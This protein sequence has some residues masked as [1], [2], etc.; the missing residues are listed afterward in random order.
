MVRAACHLTRA[1]PG[2][3]VMSDENDVKPDESDEPAERAIDGDPESFDR[4]KMRY[5]QLCEEGRPGC[6][7]LRGA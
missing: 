4:L 5:E 6:A 2:I 3:D 1:Y 7:M